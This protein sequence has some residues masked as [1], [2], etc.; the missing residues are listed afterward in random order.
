[1]GEF[2]KYLPGVTLNRNGSDGINIALGGVPSSGTPILLDG[3]GIASAASSNADRTV[4]FENIAVGSMSRVEVSRSPTPDAPAAAIGGSVNLISRSAFERSRPSYTFR[5]YASFRGGDFSWS[6]EPGP[7]QNAE[8]PWEP[9][10]ELSAIVPVTKN[11]GFTFSG[12]MARTRNNGPGITQDWAHWVS[13]I[14]IFPAS[15]GCGN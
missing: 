11:F 4:E 8:Y 13:S 3:N 6:K 14:R 2:A 1:M 5:T 15:F 12:L 7:F 9:N 10:V